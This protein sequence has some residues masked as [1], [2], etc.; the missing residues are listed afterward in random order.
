M[1]ELLVVSMEVV[2]FIG[3]NVGVR[4][5]VK[6]TS[7]KSLLHFDIVVTKSVFSGDFI[8]LRE[9]IDSLEFIETLIKVA[10][11]GT[12]RPQ[13]VPLVTISVIEVVGLQD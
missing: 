2:E 5:E 11:A 12:C 9:V 1:L 10:L 8:T 7:A 6:L 13:N 4:N 3:K